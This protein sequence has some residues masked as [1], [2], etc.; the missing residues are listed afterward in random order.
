LRK[1]EQALLEFAG[2][3]TVPVDLLEL[4][5]VVDLVLE[6]SLHD[7]LADFLDAVDE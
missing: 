2:L 5:L 4:L 3:V 1:F 6:S 7:V